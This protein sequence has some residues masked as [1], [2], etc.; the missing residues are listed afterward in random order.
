MGQRGHAGQRGFSPLS[1]NY[2]WQRIFTWPTA[3]LD[4]E[5]NWHKK[6][7]IWLF[8]IRR[9]SLLLVFRMFD[10]TIHQDKMCLAFFSR[11]NIKQSLHGE[12]AR[13]KCN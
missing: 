13:Y 9:L 8:L 10:R 3:A 5:T 11:K 2:E 12:I 7:A 6:S 4:N 1:Q